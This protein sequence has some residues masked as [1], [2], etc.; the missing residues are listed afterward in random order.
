MISP[1]EHGLKLNVS[2]LA[3]LLGPHHLA[4]ADALVSLGLSHLESGQSAAAQ[5][6]FR[7]ALCIRRLTVAETDE[8]VAQIFY[9]TGLCQFERGEFDHAR[10]SFQS[11][12]DNYENE[13][14]PEDAFLA[15]VLDA[16]AGLCQDRDQY[17]QAESYLKRSLFIRLC[18]LDPA[19][20]AIAESLNHLGWLYSQHGYYKRA[21]SLL[22]S[23]LDIWIANYGLGHA[24]TAMCLENYAYVLIKTG[25]SR[26]ANQLLSRVES[27]RSPK[28]SGMV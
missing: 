17:I 1:K 3:S 7:K 10:Q 27:I 8:T 15:S 5:K 21:E 19:D 24:A 11:C 9:Y 18:V 12:L 20:P 6:S 2:R 14:R 13:N 4:V 28:G 26:E 23:A 22:L 25:R 16:L